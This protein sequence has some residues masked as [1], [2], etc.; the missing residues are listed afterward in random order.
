MDRY[1]ISIFT[2]YRKS[3]NKRFSVNCKYIKKI[4]CQKKISSREKTLDLWYLIHFEVETQEHRKVHKMRHIKIMS[5]FWLVEKTFA[6]IQ[7]Y[8]Q[9]IALVHK[10]APDGVPIFQILEIFTEIHAYENISAQKLLLA[11]GK[12]SAIFWLLPENIWSEITQKILKFG[13]IISFFEKLICYYYEVE[14]NI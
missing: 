4:F 3:W 8:L 9:L 12:I 1:V 5:E 6:Q 11:R 14:Y 13:R 7:N 10:Q 2:K